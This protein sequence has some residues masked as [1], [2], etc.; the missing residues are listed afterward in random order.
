MKLK[1]ALL[2][3]LFS[4]LSILAPVSAQDNAPD[5]H[6]LNLTDVDIMILIEDVG[7]ITGNSFVVHPDVRANVNVSSPT[8]LSTR[9]VFEVFLATL[10][11]HGYAAVPE[12]R[13]VYRIV[14]EEL[15][16]LEANGRGAPDGV[17]FTEV[18][19]LD[20]FNA[21]EAAKL[22][23]PLLGP[24][25][26]VNASN[27]SNAVIIVERRSNIERVRRI[28]SELDLDQTTTRTVKLTSM[29]VTEMQLSLIH[30]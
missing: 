7:T 5:G 6:I 22:V 30:I 23:Q 19:R 14:P 17:F 28:L 8:P 15:A 21:V 25:G 2:G 29:S 24:Q 27:T 26:K 18:F 10:R 20:H 3:G 1:Y 9:G 4:S 16:S 12:G 11:V 13:N